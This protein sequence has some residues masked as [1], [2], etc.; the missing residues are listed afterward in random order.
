[1]MRIEIVCIWMA[2]ILMWLWHSN[3]NHFKRLL[4]IHFQIFSIILFWVCDFFGVVVQKK[5]LHQSVFH[6][7]FH[8][9]CS[10]EIIYTHKY[11]DYKMWSSCIGYLIVW[12]GKYFETC[13]RKWHVL[14][15]YMY[16]LKIINVSNEW[17]IISMQNRRWLWMYVCVCVCGVHELWCRNIDRRL[18]KWVTL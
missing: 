1:M 7:H 3:M 2:T 17:R 16:M 6:L 12:I 4:F 14:K 9:I 8:L 11:F 10:Y 13:R 5:K 15:T 18:A